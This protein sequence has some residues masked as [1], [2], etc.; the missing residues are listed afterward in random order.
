LGGLRPI[1]AASAAPDSSERVAGSAAAPRICPYHVSAGA[2]KI[3]GA[4]DTCQQATPPL[5]SPPSS[6]PSRARR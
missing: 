3:R 1:T 5:K 2:L 6:S 4:V